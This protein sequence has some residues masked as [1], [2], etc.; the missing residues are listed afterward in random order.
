MGLRGPK[1]ARFR[2]HQQRVWRTFLLLRALGYWP[3]VMGHGGGIR[4]VVAKR[5][6]LTL[7]RVTALL[8]TTTPEGCYNEDIQRTQP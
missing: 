8:N 6:G 5:T 3:E 7:Q 2:P 1:P 4:E